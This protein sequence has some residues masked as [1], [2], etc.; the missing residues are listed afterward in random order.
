MRIAIAAGGTGGHIY[1][2]IAVAQEIKSKDPSAVIL[3]VGSREGLEKDLVPHAGFNIKLIWA[4]ALLR[5]L[6][7][8][9]VSAPFISAVGFFQSLK[10]LKD[11]SPSV[12][13]S[14]GGYVSLPVVLAAKVLGI[15]ILLHEQNILPGVV[16]R[17]CARF[18]RQVFLTFEDSLKLMAGEVVGNPVRQEIISVDRSS[19]RQQL[20]LREDQKM[21]LVMGG[22]QGSRHINQAVWEAATELPEGVCVHHIIGSRDY[23]HLAVKESDRYHPLDYVYAVAPLLAAA[24]LVVSRAGATAMAEFL[25]RHLPMILIPFPYSAED[26]QRL[27]ARFA[28]KSGAAIVIEDVDFNAGAFIRLL[29]NTGLNYA[30]MQTAAAAL[31]KPAAGKIITD[32]IYANF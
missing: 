17:F 23:G 24:D 26:H 28:N 30:K 9:A 32:Y 4:R 12:V 20:G 7:Y 29:E 27:N 22:S 10:V 31:A 6:S 14:T 16:N 13:F 11:F 21:V 3:F 15:P 18:A 8:K 2:G 19:A 5:K 1:P 25:V